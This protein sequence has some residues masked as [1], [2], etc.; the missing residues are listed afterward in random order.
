MK[1]LIVL[2]RRWLV[3]IAAVIA[4]AAVLALWQGT[5]DNK[6]A[7]VIETANGQ[8]HAFGVEIADTPQEQAQGLMG[9]TQ[10]AD[11]EGMIFLFGQSPRIISFWMKNTLIPLD[12][13]F[14]KTDGTIAHIHANARPHDLTSISSQTPVVAVLEINGG[15]SARLGIAE[16]DRVV[17]ESLAP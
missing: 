2:H 10:M 13:I 16:G 9:R 7:L 6:H 15:L 11:D 14:I 17:H 4:I 3:V 5:V 12:M 1:K 8:T